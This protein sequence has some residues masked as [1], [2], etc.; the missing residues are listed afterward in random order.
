[1]GTAATPFP[2]RVEPDNGPSG[3]G[4]HMMRLEADG[5]IGAGSRSGVFNETQWAG[6]YTAQGIT[7]I[8]MDLNNLGFT[9]L[10]IRIGLRGSGGDIASVQSFELADNS[11]WTTVSFPIEPG[12]FTG[13]GVDPAA[14]LA[15]V[16]QFRIL[17]NPLP[18]FRGEPILATLGIDNIRSAKSV[19]GGGGA[20]IISRFQVTSDPDVADPASEVVL[21][22]QPQ[23]YGNHNG[24]QIAFSPDGYLYVG[25]GDGGAGGD[26]E[27]HGQNLGDLLGAMLRLDVPA[28]P[29]DPNPTLSIPPDNPFVGIAGARDEI[30]AYG[31][32]NPWRFSFDRS[33]GDLFIADVGQNSLEEVNFQFESSPGGE[34][35]GWRLMEGS[36]CF[37]PQNNC[38]NG[39][40]TLPVM[41]YNHS[42]G[43]SVTGGYRYRGRLYPSIEE[44][45]SSVTSV[46]GR[47]GVG[48][49]SPAARGP[50]K[51][52]RA[53]ASTFRPLARTKTARCM[54]RIMAPVPSTVWTWL[55]ILPR[56]PPR[57]RGRS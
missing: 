6:D 40:L 27:N 55:W 3:V 49:R 23:P 31:L 38:N 56:S 21:L 4:D 29:N 14:T 35:Y 11:G 7:E 57:F 33:T 16:T 34:N 1:M 2:P 10:H 54:S 45:F 5:G 17:H 41:E 52:W 50:N 46:A 20:T 43:C 47:S 18:D 9:T 24:G 28:D 25:L 53:P 22:A 8:S 44:S 32:R 48:P 30:W 37:N 42:Q 12:E 39:T 26:P 36:S 19:N 15:S 51:W 13:T